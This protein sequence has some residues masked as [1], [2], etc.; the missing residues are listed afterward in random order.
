MG[1]DTGI[2]RVSG[3]YLLFASGCKRGRNLE[4]LISQ[5]ASKISKSGARLQLINPV[6]LFPPGTNVKEVRRTLAIITSKARELGMTVGKGHTEI[7][8]GLDQPTL[9]LTIF[10]SITAPKKRQRV[11]KP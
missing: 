1:M 8:P 2:V 6:V 7:T 5:V 3:K 9:M 4:D 11:S 10:G